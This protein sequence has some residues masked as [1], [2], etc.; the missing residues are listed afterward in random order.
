MREQLLD[1]LDVE[2]AVLRG[3]VIP[4]VSS[5][6]KPRLASALVTAYNRHLVDEWFPCNS[7]AGE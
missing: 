7:R 3:E 5:L 6:P 2:Y 1:P 4:S